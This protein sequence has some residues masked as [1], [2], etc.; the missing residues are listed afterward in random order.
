MAEATETMNK[1]Q[2]YYALHR[3]QKLSKYHN[4]PEVITR[5]EERERK[6]A[7]KEV[8]KEIKQAEKEKKRQEV[9]QLALATKKSVKKS[10]GGLN[11][12]LD[13]IPPVEKT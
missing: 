2:R 13:G 12:F 7:E 4:D 8:E 1:Y 11:E 6:K 3:E 9:L 5:R 10:E